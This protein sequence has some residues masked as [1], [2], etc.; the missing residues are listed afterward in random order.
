MGRITSI[1]L[2][3]GNS[4]IN[5]TAITY[6]PGANGSRTA[7]VSTYK[8][9][10]DSAYNSEYDENGNI[11]SITKGSQSFTYV[12]D[13]ANQLI[14]ENLYYGSGNSKALRCV[15][16]AKGFIIRILFQQ[17]SWDHSLT[18]QPVGTGMMTQIR[19]VINLL[20]KAVPMPQKALF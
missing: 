18:P 12:Y 20:S 2:K 15:S 6:V 13:A 19:L 9:G 8:N 3:N 11:T 10:N 5:D 16:T 14:R 4:T 17:A 7:L 1:K